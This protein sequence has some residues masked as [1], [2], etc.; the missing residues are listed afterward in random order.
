MFNL[1]FKWKNSNPKIKT[2]DC[3]SDEE[4]L[5]GRIRLFEE[6]C[7]PSVREQSN[8]NFEWVVLFSDRTPE[9][10]KKIVADYES[11]ISCFKALYFSDE[12]TRNFRN[13]LVQYIKRTPADVYI[14]SRCDNDD[15]LN[16]NYKKYIQDYVNQAD[17][18]MPFGFPPGGKNPVQW[19]KCP[20][21]V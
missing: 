2:I 4:Y 12:E 5:Q 17:N 11:K 21:A 6:Y 18:P 9:N 13:L 1:N 14:T 7:I 16:V 3:S 10:I 19:W 8:Q 20:D 15:V